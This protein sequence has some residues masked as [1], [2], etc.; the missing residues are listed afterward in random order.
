MNRATVAGYWKVAEKTSREQH[1]QNGTRQEGK[2]EGEIANVDDTSKTL[3]SKEFQEALAKTQANGTEVI[4]N[5][6]DA[7]KGLQLV[8]GMLEEQ[9]GL[10]D[11][12]VMDVE[13]IKAHVLELGLD[14]DA[15]DDLLDSYEERGEEELMDQEDGWKLQGREVMGSGADELEAGAGEIAKKNGSRKRLFKAP[16]GT[17]GSAKMRLASALASPRKRGTAKPG[18]RQGDTSR[19]MESKGTSNPKNGIPKP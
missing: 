5:V 4:S 16:T 1:D 9:S 17:A 18:N 6:G 12:E 7:E 2:E 8:H 19:H 3:P 13:A 11:E 15:T 10:D 14:I